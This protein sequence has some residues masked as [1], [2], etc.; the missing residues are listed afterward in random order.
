V[1]YAVRKA[2]AKARSA[3]VFASTYIRN[4]GKRNRGIRSKRG[5]KKQG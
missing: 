3:P 4:R 5:K 1:P 2:R